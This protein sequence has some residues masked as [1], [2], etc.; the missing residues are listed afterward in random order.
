MLILSRMLNRIQPRRAPIAR[1][2]HRTTK[3]SFSKNAF[4]SFF[5]LNL[6]AFLNDAKWLQSCLGFHPIGGR[7]AFMGLRSPRLAFLSH[8]ETQVDQVSGVFKLLKIDLGSYISTE[9]YFQQFKTTGKHR[10]SIVFRYYQPRHN[11]QDASSSCP[12]LARDLVDLFPRNTS[13]GA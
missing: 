1:T 3:S 9:A 2:P 5:S 7:H 12:G 11:F 6:N 10:N 8:T 4:F 13:L